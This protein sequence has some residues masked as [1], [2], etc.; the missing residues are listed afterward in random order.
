VILRLSLKDILHDWLLSTC[1]VLAI[2]SIIAPL[3]ILFGLKFGTI[4]TLRNR[5]VDDPKNCEI[6][7][8]SVQSFNRDWFEKIKLEIPDIA[9]VEP[10]T[11]QISTSITAKTSAGSGRL[12]LMAT[13]AGD[14]LLLDNG[15][16]IPSVDS[17]VLTEP[18]A[19]VLKADVG[20]TVTFRV[21]RILGGKSENGIFSV[22]VSGILDPRASSLK[23][24]FVQLTVVEAVEDYKDGRAVSA[25][26]WQGELPTAYPVYQ[27][28]AVFTPGPLSKLDEILLVNNT[29]FAGVTQISGDAAAAALGF[30]P[31]HEWT[32]YLA[33]VRKRP[34]TEDSIQAVRNKLRGKGA[35][36]LPWVRPFKVSLAS[37]QPAI[38][39]IHAVTEQVGRVS[40]LKSKPFTRADQQR[41]VSL[42]ADVLP[43]MN[44]T[45]LTVS[46]E[47]RNLSVPVM[48]FHREDTRPAA[49]ADASFV[50]RLNLFRER[51]V[52]YDK[53]SNSLLLSRRGYA[54]F[55]MY[56][57][58]IDAVESV[59]R[60]LE[61]RGIAVHTRKERIGEVRRLD[62]YMSLIFWL[63]AA[64]G[65]VG[66]ISALTASL[67]ASVERKKKELNILRLLGLLKREIILFPVFQGLL[68][69][70]AG[71][72]LATTVFIAVSRVINHLFRSHLQAKE[73]LCTLSPV[74]FV[75]LVS[76]VFLLSVV[77]A[78][79]AA[80][81]ATRLDPAEALR[82]E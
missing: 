65:V 34:A 15:V 78:A 45:I 17:C 8:I 30:M 51:D 75:I 68:L 46:G 21:R 31:H 79:F 59:G 40:A 74:H 23:T 66:G 58:T 61:E 4:Q 81:Q 39:T 28:A 72:I 26:G 73:S 37:A 82:D 57:A 11:R 76:G 18:A 55:R 52:K 14:P 64:V 6:R 49:F 32:V 54:G 56:A 35:V 10:M 33:G 9:F 13:A 36:V 29:G 2:A 48:I 5:L 38:V 69:S 27:G 20:D 71:L 25:Y 47:G 44:T 16:T 12:S 43:D 7:P 24:A 67:Y 80:L 63:I 1:L 53:Q 3:L 77:S 41:V 42:P 50:G 22:K 70:G 19:Q 62:K 60:Q